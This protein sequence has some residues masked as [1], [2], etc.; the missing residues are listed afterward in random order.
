MPHLSDQTP[1]FGAAVKENIGEGESKANSNL[2]D[3]VNNENNDL[4]M[5][6]F[7]EQ[8]QIDKNIVETGR[9]QISKTT[10]SRQAD[11]DADLISEDTVVETVPVGLR[12]DVMPKTRVEGD[13]TIVP[14]VEEVLY[15][16]KRLFL[17][18]ELRIT[19][20]RS[21]R[22]VHDTVTLRHQEAVV[23]RVQSATENHPGTSGER[24]EKP[25]E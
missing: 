15:T 21:T 4:R 16:E 22:H 12:I 3:I 10:I 17:K 20:R 25:Q 13:T 24:T 1:A 2:S 5:Q 11:I 9:V 7:E 18:E 8:I 23:S 14:I 6:L 19:R